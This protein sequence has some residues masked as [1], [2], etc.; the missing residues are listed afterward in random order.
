ML[1]APVV[2]RVRAV[3]GRIGLPTEIADLPESPDRETVRAH[4]FCDKKR[5]GGRLA[6]VL[7]RETGRAVVVEDGDEEEVLAAVYGT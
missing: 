5:K 1:E 2:E 3:L 6:L 4:L 7:L